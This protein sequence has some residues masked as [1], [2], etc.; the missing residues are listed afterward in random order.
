MSIP[1]EDMLALEVPQQSTSAAK[2]TKTVNFKFNRVFGM[3]TTQNDIFKEV[4]EVVQVKC[5]CIIFRIGLH[6]RI[7]LIS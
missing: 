4:K 5:I 1:T 6:V 7:V 3:S 2:T